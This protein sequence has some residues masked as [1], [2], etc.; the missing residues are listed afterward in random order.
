MASKPTIG[1]LLG[2]SKDRPSKSDGDDDAKRVAAKAIL[3]AIG[4]KDAQ[5]LSDALESFSEA[6]SLAG[7]DEDEDDDET[8]ED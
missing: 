1:L 3:R 4:S 2:L 8:E 5:A 7:L 6:C